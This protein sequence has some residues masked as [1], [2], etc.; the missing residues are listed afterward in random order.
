MRKAERHTEIER[1]RQAVTEKE[2]ERN[3]VRD[4]MKQRQN[5]TSLRERK[6]ERTKGGPYWTTCARKLG[7]VSKKRQSSQTN[8][9]ETHKDTTVCVRYAHAHTHTELHTSFGIACWRSTFSVYS[10]AERKRKPL[11]AAWMRAAA[12]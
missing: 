7:M 8:P 10:A 2:M 4:R 11:T 1:V 12:A 3:R 5:E 9:C 6:I